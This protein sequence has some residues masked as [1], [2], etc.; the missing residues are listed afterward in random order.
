[1]P[2]STQKRTAD[3]SGYLRFEF[4]DGHS[5]VSSEPTLSHI[6]S[7]PTAD[8]KPRPAAAL[9]AASDDDAT[10]V[11]EK[12]PAA[13]VYKSSNVKRVFSAAYHKAVLQ[14]KKKCISTGAEYKHDVAKELGRKAGHKASILLNG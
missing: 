5:W 1:M 3:S 4:A 10:S 6:E 9:S 7:R 11:I 2:L 14:Y 12:K 13:H 8:F